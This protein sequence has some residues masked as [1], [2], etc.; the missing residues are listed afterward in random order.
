M[1]SNFAVGAIIIGVVEVLIGVYV[2]PVVIS[3][4]TGVDLILENLTG[5]GTDMNLSWLAVI[6]II[7]FGIAIAILPFGILYLVL[8]R[9][10]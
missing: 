8:N 7:L 10:K 1:A 2:L 4:W 3:G 6:G 9:A 5:D